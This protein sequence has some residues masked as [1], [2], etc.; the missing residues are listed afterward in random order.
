MHLST[1]K[2]LLKVEFNIHS[3][4]PTKTQK[5]KN[6]RI[7]YIQMYTTALVTA[8]LCYTACW[9]HLFVFV[10]KYNLSI[11]CMFLRTSGDINNWLFLINY[12]LYDYNITLCIQYLAAIFRYYR[13]VW[14]LWSFVIFRINELVVFFAYRIYSSCLT[15][16]YTK[17]RECRIKN[18]FSNK[19]SICSLSGL[20]TATFIVKTNYREITS[21]ISETY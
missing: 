3:L 10:L 8:L 9:N 11:N 19:L 20:M 6:V 18:I 15:F 7:L 21:S 14:K 12:R 5:K 4:P 16:R 2:V 17:Y 13:K 1:I